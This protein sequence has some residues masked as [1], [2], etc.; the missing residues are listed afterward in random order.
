[1]AEWG[2][3]ARET[4]W[5][6]VEYG[7][8]LGDIPGWQGQAFVRDV[9]AGVKYFQPPE[10][11]GLRTWVRRSTSESDRFVMAFAGEEPPA[12]ETVLALQKKLAAKRK[13]L[14]DGDA[15][16]EKLDRCIDQFLAR[17][18]ELHQR[19]VPLG[20]VQPQSVVFC[21]EPGAPDTVQLP[22]LGFV[23]DV[24]AWVMARPS[25]IGDAANVMFDETARIRNKAYHDW[26]IAQ[27]DETFQALAAE[28]IRIAG[29]LIAFALAGESEVRKWCGEGRPLA[30]IPAPADGANDTACRAVWDVLHRAIRGELQSITELRE[31][32]TA[33][34]RPS[35][36]F[37][38]KPPPS[39][40][41]QW[42]IWLRRSALP[43]A[44]AVAALFVTWAGYK[45]FETFAP[46]Y[47]KVC[48]HVTSWNKTLFPGLEDLETEA[49]SA[50]ASDEAKQRF[51]ESLRAYIGL[52]R[53][54]PGHGCD[55]SCTEQLLAKTQPWIDQEV[56]LVVKG[57]AEQPRPTSK[58]VVELTEKVAR[59]ADLNSLR[60]GSSPPLFQ[61]AMAKLD[62]QLLLRG[63]KPALQTE[64]SEEEPPR[65]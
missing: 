32:L 42:K 52:L 33:D 12:S 57:L 9:A 3:T 38:V 10:I 24:D 1:M 44:A 20:F 14:K 4:S 5:T 6:P 50:A 22:D 61:A 2:V 47:T 17:V 56:D 55:E 54:N 40:D 23:F 53:A 58:E 63:E 36:H 26:T 35:R 37:L 64:T 45:A 29:R 60:R 49:D 59:I 11:D 21:S 62:R 25:W 18:A 16:L 19:Q 51:L 41:P 30:E 8:D 34:S 43:I 27:N 48:K 15:D 13:T 46:R 31:L 28:D 65:R 39:P 7:P